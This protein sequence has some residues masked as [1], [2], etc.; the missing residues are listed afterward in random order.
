MTNN[1]YKEKVFLCSEYKTQNIELNGKIISAE[2]SDD[3]CKRELG[4]S[5]K[6]TLP[7]N[8]GMFFIFPENGNYQF[9]MKD[10]RFP[11][12]IIWISEDFSI[13]HIEKNIAPSTYP[14]VFGK[15]IFAKYVLEVY[16]GFSEKNNLKVGNKLKI[17]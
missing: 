16:S 2:I 6:E 3:D 7:N 9:W 17:D 1:K 13:V 4:L 12:D 15:N 14:S 10:M 11:I 8:E 5:F